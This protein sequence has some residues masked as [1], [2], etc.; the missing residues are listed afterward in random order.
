MDERDNEF[1]VID[2]TTGA[3]VES[4]FAAQP[5]APDI[6]AREHIP[7]RRLVAGIALAV[8]AVVLV[9]TIL[10]QVRPGLAQTRRS[11]SERPA[12][13]TTAEVYFQ[14]SVP[15][16]SLRIDGRVS[17]DIFIAHPDQPMTVSAGRHT[18]VYEAAPFPPLACHFSVPA[19]PVDDCL[20]R[21]NDLGQIALSLKDDP[22]RLPS[23]QIAALSAAISSALANDV[24]ITRVAPGERYI[25][26]DGRITVAN[27]PLVARMTYALG[28]AGDS[29]KAP[30]EVACPDFCA[31]GDVAVLPSGRYAWML[32]APISVNWQYAALD[33]TVVAGSAPAALAPTPAFA[34]IGVGVWYDGTWHAISP[35][36]TVDFSSPEN[37]TCA[38]AQAELRAVDLIPLVSYTM[39]TSSGPNPA[40]GCLIGVTGTDA[41][42]G[43]TAGIHALY[44][45]RF[46]VMLAANAGAH[47]IA[48]TLPVVAGQTELDLVRMLASHIG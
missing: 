21:S 40:D 20:V 41:A 5:D 35:T 4:P 8:L 48:P 31:R 18:L 26:P 16:G 6:P 47:H 13:P 24:W 2:L 10:P 1:E 32:R 15:W 43:Q 29:A 12:L 37:A 46:G 19:S 44:L 30:P 34:T 39:G 11:A 25:A 9:A 42:Y 36:R 28:V 27:Q 14:N 38:V 33:G 7:N 23:D 22:S 3:T 45:Y 17:G